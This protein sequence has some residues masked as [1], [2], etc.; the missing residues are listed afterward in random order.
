MLT[1]FACFNHILTDR[2]G[3]WRF[4]EVRKLPINDEELKPGMK[5]VRRTYKGN[6]RMADKTDL[7][8][9]WNMMVQITEIIIEVNTTE[10][11]PGP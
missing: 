9:N 4:E 3:W 8:S 6:S 1:S 5:V 7:W 2:E 10:Q 11:V